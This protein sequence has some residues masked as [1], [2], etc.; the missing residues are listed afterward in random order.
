M[1]QNIWKKR[2]RHKISD[3]LFFDNA[4]KTRVG[5]YAR[6]FVWNLSKA[7]IL[8][9][10]DKKIAFERSL[11]NLKA[12]IMAGGLG[13]R[14]K[15][16]TC[17]LPKPLVPIV[18]EPVLEYLLRLLQHHGFEDVIV[19]LQY[20]P[21]LIRKTIGSEPKGLRVTYRQETQSLGTAGSIGNV[22][23][24][25]NETF[26]VISGDA[27]TDL[28]IG[29][30]LD[31]H[32]KKGAKA[33]IVLHREAVPLEYGVVLPDSNG[34]V[35]R[36]LEKPD[37]SEVFSDTVNTGMYILEPSVLDDI[38][39]DGTSDFAKDI[40]PAMLE[41]GDKIACFCMDGY[42]CDIG[43]VQ[44]YIA[45]QRDMLHGVLA[46]HVYHLPQGITVGIGA[47]IAE[48]ACLMPPV[49]IG[50]YA[51]IG[52]HAV[53]GPDTVIGRGCRIQ[54][55]ASV[56]RSVLW[57]H[58]KIGHSAVVRGAVCCSQAAVGARTR[59]FDGVVLGESCCIGEDALV[60][61]QARV[62]PQ[63]KITDGAAVRENC[64]YADEPTMQEAS[65]RMEGCWS[66][67]EMLSLG[68][69]F[70]TVLGEKPLIVCGGDVQ[71]LSAQAF[72]CGAAEAGA[73]CFSASDVSLGVLRTIIRQLSLDG[74]IHVAR[75]G[76]C[77]KVTLLSQNG[78]DF[79]AQQE[80]KLREWCLRQDTPLCVSKE[81][82]AVLE[83]MERIHIRRILK[84]LGST[85]VLKRIQPRICL[86][87]PR[88]LCAE[89]LFDGTLC[90][91][92]TTEGED[93]LRM[94]IDPDGS[95]CTIS[96]SRG[97]RLDKEALRILQ[98]VSL[99][100]VLSCVPV[101]DDAPVC[102]EKLLQQQKKQIVRIPAERPRFFTALS[103]FDEAAM[104]VYEDAYGMLMF[105]L[106]YLAEEG[107]SLA[108]WFDALPPLGQCERTL[109]CSPQQKGLIMRFLA[110]SD[111]LQTQYVDA[112]IRIFRGSASALVRPDRE[113]PKL[114]LISQAQDMEAAQEL[115][116]FLQTRIESIKESE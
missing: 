27:L 87:G 52:E 63:R 86:Q 9:A 24:L 100:R 79:S 23:D 40:F 96:D 71:S 69:A 78:S 57:E 85:D 114:A 26:L 107:L 47:Q 25:L 112:G 90:R 50:P 84:K 116:D 105:A 70:S 101:P 33:T 34:F 91:I 76:T 54:D 92:R 66:A 21:H 95:A 16:M 74:G 35:E 14:L 45:A 13:T 17:S 75:S 94:Q 41:R 7:Y 36:F 89:D 56:K 102:L 51:M 64:I 67:H 80:K 37:W 97:R 15:P 109:A 31:Y 43:S 8:T 46:P 58:V 68:H 32:R 30:A 55:G 20:L 18:N 99:A 3:A 98:A 103:E 113:K 6:F 29:A 2:S 42:W 60:T 39:A 104:F 10:R 108:Q 22:R 62:W 12:V 1:Y 115:A 53:I 83:G 110:S 5:N 81:K 72:L 44:S 38:P 48:T 61:A 77:Q 93:M 49:V 82:F 19:T 11:T 88:L 106:C 65:G 73:V 111:E 59:I 4:R 28:D